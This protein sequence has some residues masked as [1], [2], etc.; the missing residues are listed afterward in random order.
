MQKR[1]SHQAIPGK[2]VM[3]ENQG[4]VTDASAESGPVPDG[5]RRRSGWWLIVC[6]TLCGLGLI[7]Y[8]IFGPSRAL[9]ADEVKFLGT[10]DWSDPAKPGVAPTKIT[11]AFNRQFVYPDTSG[12]DSRWKVVGGR[13]KVT[14]YYKSTLYRDGPE[15]PIKHAES[16]YW[17]ILSSSDPNR[18][19]L[20][21]DMTG[22][23]YVLIRQQ[24]PQIRD[25]L[26]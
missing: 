22:T 3:L 23:E 10:W 13:L 1:P 9:S 14:H 17:T 7:T 26:E 25:T 6:V 19:R 11:F 16:F 15:L 8:R 2:T 4:E 18:I 24:P 12:L 5:D 21:M 20:R